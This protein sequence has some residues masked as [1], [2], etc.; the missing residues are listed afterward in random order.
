MLKSKYHDVIVIGA[1]HAGVEASLALAKMGFNTVIIT[2]SA[3]NIAKMSCNPAIGGLAKGHIAREIDAL[4]GE[5][6]KAIDETGIQF[7]M[8]NL[9]KGPAVW[10]PRAQADKKAYQDRMK[11]VLEQEENLSLVQDTVAELIVENAQVKGV[12]TVR[13]MEYPSG[14]VIVTTGTFLKGLIHIGEYQEKAGRMGDSSA[15]NLSDH[16]RTLGF[17]VGRLKTGTPARINKRSIDFSRVEVQ[18]S[19]NIPF[20]FSHFTSQPPKSVIDCYITYTNSKTHEIIERNLSRS[21]MFT[22]QI[23]GV[24]PRYCPSIEDKVNRFADKDRHQLFLEPEGLNTNEVYINGLSSSLPEDVQIELI[25]SIAGLENA[26]VMRIGYAVEYDF[27]NPIQLKSTLETK[28]IEGLY[29]AG[30]INGTSGYEEAA[31]QGLIAGINAGLKLKGEPPFVMDRSESY[32][33]VLID[34]LVTR[35]VQEPYRMFTSRAEYRL[36]LRY[37]NADQRLM[38]YGHK[39]GLIDDE[40]I[41]RLDEKVKA[42]HHGVSFIRERHVKSNEVTLPLY[43]AEN[44]APGCNLATILRRSNV[45]IADIVVDQHPEL[46]GLSEDV[47]KQ[48]EIEVKYEGYIHKQNEQIAR[49][50]KLESKT[51]PQDFDYDQV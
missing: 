23:Q 30:Q 14:A 35:G 2:M 16:F 33:A 39:V 6:A 8:L 29:F 24:G 11:Q 22:G 36:N 18:D 26:E 19:D 9:K 44:I 12:R 21:P 46:L 50:K 32:I 45:G 5:M 31:A 10:A 43:Q 38:R 13:G 49:F 51:I 20:S 4:G 3:D 48:I 17:E 42:I 1:G 41:R 25:Q 34:D 40:S 47:L 27:C 15:E 7:R 37:D 28:L